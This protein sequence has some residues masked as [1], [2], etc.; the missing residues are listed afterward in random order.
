L[1]SRLAFHERIQVLMAIADGEPLPHTRKFKA[2]AGKKLPDG[3]VCTKEQEDAG[4]LIEAQWEQSADLDQR[5]R[6]IQMLGSFG[7]LNV[8]VDEGG[9]GGDKPKT[10][11]AITFD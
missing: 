11:Y 3:T 5:M 9:E 2:K 4:L 6:A 8:M 7:G 1:G 10:T